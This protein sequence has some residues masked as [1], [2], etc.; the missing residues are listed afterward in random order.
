M[1]TDV[2]RNIIMSPVNSF[3]TQNDFSL[4]ILLKNTY[5]DEELLI[6]YV[7]L[8]G[9]LKIQHQSVLQNISQIN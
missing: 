4:F 9:P 3:I 1:I 6:F 5:T 2:F 7:F 8:C